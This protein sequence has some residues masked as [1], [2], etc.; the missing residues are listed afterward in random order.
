MDST[1]K[2]YGYLDI[3]YLLT[4]KK[5]F[6]WEGLLDLDNEEYMVSYLL[7]GQDTAS[8]SSFWSIGPYGMNSSCLALLPGESNSFLIKVKFGLG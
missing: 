1:E 7:S 6:S 4:S 8:L 5:L 3:T 2:V